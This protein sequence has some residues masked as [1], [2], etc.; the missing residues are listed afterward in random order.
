[1]RGATRPF[2]GNRKISEWGYQR[3]SHILHAIPQNICPVTTGPIG[4]EGVYLVLEW[5]PRIVRVEIPTVDP[6]MHRWADRRVLP[7]HHVAAPKRRHRKTAQNARSTFRELPPTGMRFPKIRIGR[8]VA[9]QSHRTLSRMQPDEE[10]G[11][12]IDRLGPRSDRGNKS[13][14]RYS[15]LDEFAACPLRGFG[16]RKTVVGTGGYVGELEQRLKR[17]ACS[18]RGRLWRGRFGF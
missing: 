4:S 8:S 12:I 3:V 14:V 5:T 15:R 9:R 2:H 16:L 1:M 6:Q 11:A 10:Y 17:Q 7:P 18:D 13:A